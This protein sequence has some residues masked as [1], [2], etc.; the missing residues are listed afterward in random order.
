MVAKED[1][2]VC[3]F[4]PT[5]LM[6]ITSFDTWLERTIWAKTLLVRFHTGNSQGLPPVDML[7]S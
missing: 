5:F 4:V 3:V 2:P 7:E 1:A 6:M